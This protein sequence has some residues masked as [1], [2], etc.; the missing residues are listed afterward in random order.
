MSVHRAIRQ[1]D[2][3]LHLPT[4]ADQDR[5]PAEA[6]VVVIELLKQLLNECA[7]SATSAESLLD[8]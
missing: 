2:L 5:L 1:R 4:A 6:R 3:L 8:E 7:V